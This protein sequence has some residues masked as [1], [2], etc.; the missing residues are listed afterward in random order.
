MQQGTTFNGK[1][2]K[3]EGSIT[4]GITVYTLTDRGDYTGTA[5]KIGSDVIDLAIERNY[6]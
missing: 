1:L 4:S 2:F 3:Y 6:P 5:I